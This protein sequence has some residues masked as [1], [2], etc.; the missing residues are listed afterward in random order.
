MVSQLN[1]EK[2]LKKRAKIIP[3]AKKEFDQISS[4]SSLSN[5]SFK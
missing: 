4:D 2:P 3:S 1:C 5:S